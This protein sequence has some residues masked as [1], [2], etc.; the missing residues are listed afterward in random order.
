MNLEELFIKFNLEG[1]V[2]KLHG[3]AAPPPTHMINSHRI[4]KFIQKGTPGIIAR[5]Y[6][7][8]GYDKTE[9]VTPELQ[10][11]L[12]HH[13]KVFKDLPKA[14]PLERE[15]DH[16]IEL[17]VGSNPPNVRPYRY[18]Y[19]QKNEIE[20]LVKELLEVRF[21][22]ESKSSFSTP[23]ILVKKKDGSFRMCVDYKEL[24]KITI[25]DKFPIPVIDELLDEL[26]GEVYFTKLDLRSGYHQI[27]IKIGDTHKMAF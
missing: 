3:S 19:Q 11:V 4:E 13:S 12:S 17:L 21:I 24:N 26:N 18:P 25:K 15:Q 10:E 2:Y 27:R 20:Q 9:S 8:E 7:I 5:C 14:L 22:K 6:S 23:V 16:A 1:K